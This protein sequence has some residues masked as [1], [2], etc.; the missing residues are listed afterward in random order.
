[1]H[2]LHLMFHICHKLHLCP[3]AVQIVMFPVDTEICIAVQVICQESHAALQ[4]QELCGEWEK[5]GRAHV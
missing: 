1:M 4:S 2:I 3:A 5:I